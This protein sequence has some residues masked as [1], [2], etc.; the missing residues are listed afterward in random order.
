MD[1][2]YY[3]LT[4]RAN[5]TSS[6]AYYALQPTSNLQVTEGSAHIEPKSASATMVTVESQALQIQAPAGTMHGGVTIVTAEQRIDGEVMVSPP[7]DSEVEVI[8]FGA[9]GKKL[10]AYVLA[11]GEGNGV[12]QFEV[13][14]AE[15][16][17]AG[18]ARK[19][20]KQV[21]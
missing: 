11:A 21:L 4:I 1:Q 15:A 8:L 14:A 10:G 2:L 20:L 6:A 16:I 18:D 17:P 5:R 3:A 13:D 7:I 9:G 19:V 12:F